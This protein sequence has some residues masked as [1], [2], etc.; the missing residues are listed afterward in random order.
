M[1]TRKNPSDLTK[2][3]LDFML[4][5]DIQERVIGQLGYIPVSKMEIERDWQGNVIK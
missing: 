3:F 5:D 1:Y 4:S 2:E